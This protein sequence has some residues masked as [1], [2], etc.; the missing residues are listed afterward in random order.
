MYPYTRSID[1]IISSVQSNIQ[2]N[3][4]EKKKDLVR[5]EESYKGKKE[6]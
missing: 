2:P 6:E 4:M 1:L 5:C 3:R